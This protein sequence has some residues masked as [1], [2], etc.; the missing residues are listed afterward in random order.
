VRGGGQVDA[1]DGQLGSDRE[2]DDRLVGF[3]SEQV[4]DGGEQLVDR[5]NRQLHGSLL[6]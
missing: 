3:E 6:R 1:G 4:R 2:E 5:A